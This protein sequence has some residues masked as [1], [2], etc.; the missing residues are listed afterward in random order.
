MGNSLGFWSTDFNFAISAGGV[1]LL[2]ADGA[3]FEHRLLED[4]VPLIY[5]RRVN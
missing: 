4:G 1:A 2:D 5:Q 3:G